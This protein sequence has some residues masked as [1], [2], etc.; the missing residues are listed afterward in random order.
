MASRGGISGLSVAIAAVGGFLVYAGIKDVP[1][2]EGLREII[3]G[4]T[5]TGREA[6]KTAVWTG[7]A[8]VGNAAAGFA[9]GMA[10]VKNYSLPGVQPHV[11]HAADEIGTMTRATYMGGF[12]AGDLDHGRGLAVDAGCQSAAHN[13][14]IAA[15]G[16]ANRDR[17][18][19]TYIIWNMKIASASKGWT[20]RPYKPIT[21]SG[22]F[23]HEKHTHFSF[24]AAHTYRPPNS[25]A[26]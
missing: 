25:R 20:I 26:I 6:K 3:G 2:L 22:D 17:L 14:S 15:Y 9:E 5:P 4:K 8:S 18:G 10:G 1:L 12:R 21:T 7:G 24:K 19:L 13:E 23:R 16:M 11:K